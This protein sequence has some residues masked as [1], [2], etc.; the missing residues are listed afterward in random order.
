MSYD[1]SYAQYIDHSV[2]KPET[3]KATLKKFCDEA[4]EY[5]F[6][7]VAVNP[8][9]IPYVVEQLKGSGVLAGA[10][11]LRLQPHVIPGDAREARQIDRQPAQRQ[12][13]ERH[14]KRLYRCKPNGLFQLFQPQHQP[15][16]PLPHRRRQQ[17]ARQQAQRKPVPA[18]AA[19][20]I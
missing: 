11:H 10:D 8:Y 17:R 6:A 3:T 13:A 18:G 2:L 4:K 20:F 12:Q 15:D 7:S 14:A 19:V 1:A 9:N 16:E 5:H